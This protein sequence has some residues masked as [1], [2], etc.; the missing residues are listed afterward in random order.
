MNLRYVVHC[1][2]E[3]R[4]QIHM[5]FKGIK[6]C[7]QNMTTILDSIFTKIGGGLYDRFMNT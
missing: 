1:S 5:C 6:S 4:Y 2:F 7:A 3:H